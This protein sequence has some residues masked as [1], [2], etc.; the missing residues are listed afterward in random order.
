MNILRAEQFVKCYGARHELVNEVYHA[1]DMMQDCL[2]VMFPDFDLTKVA[3][4]TLDE[5]IAQYEA[6]PR[7]IQ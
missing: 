7:P 6:N 3:H 2:H 4:L 5:L 1:D